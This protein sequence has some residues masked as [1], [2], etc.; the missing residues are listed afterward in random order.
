[1]ARIGGERGIINVTMGTEKY[2]ADGSLRDFADS[3]QDV[4]DNDNNI[5]RPVTLAAARDDVAEGN[6]SDE[7]HH[8]CDDNTGSSLILKPQGLFLLSLLS[9][10]PNL[11]DFTDFQPRPIC[12]ICQKSISLY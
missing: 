1:M 9:Q 6:A 4:P 3:G 10:G 7:S 5:D 11:I 2:A 8:L 12:Q